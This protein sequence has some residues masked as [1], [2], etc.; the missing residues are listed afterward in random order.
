MEVT[1]VDVHVEVISVEGMDSSDA[2]RFQREL[3]RTLA[4]LVEERGLS[5][6]MMSSRDLGVIVTELKPTGDCRPTSLADR[7]AE[8]VYGVLIG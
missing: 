8:A 5:E 6:L 2:S 3:E 7:V 4:R 1:A